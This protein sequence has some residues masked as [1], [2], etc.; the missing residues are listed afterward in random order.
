M[1]IEL[2]LMPGGLPSF[3]EPSFEALRSQEAKIWT[4]RGLEALGTE[5]KKNITHVRG[6]RVFCIAAFLG[7]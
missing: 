5:A 2:G 7:T 4:D 1:R 3:P 6:H